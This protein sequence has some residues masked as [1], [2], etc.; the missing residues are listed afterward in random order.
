MPVVSWHVTEPAF[1]VLKQAIWS[2]S[3]REPARGTIGWG[4]VRAA[5]PI[6][7]PRRDVECP[8]CPAPH[9]ERPGEGVVSRNC[10]SALMNRTETRTENRTAT[11]DAERA[12]RHESR[13]AAEELRR[14][15]LRAGV[16]QAAVA[17]AVGTTRSLICRLEQGDPAVALRMRFRV[18]A[19][20]GADLRLMA[21][22]GSGPVIRDSV[23]AEVVEHLLRVRNPGWRATVE[24]DVPGPG[25]RSVDLR[26]DGPADTI[27]VEV[28]TRVDSLEGIVRELHAKR[29]AILE[30]FGAGAI[31]R[32]HVVLVLPVTRRHST[33]VKAHPEIIR[34]AFPVPSAVIRRALT[35]PATTC[36][37][38][39]LLWIRR[40][41]TVV[42]PGMTERS[43]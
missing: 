15:R 2:G 12:L 29:R 17:A 24:A 43:L 20:L 21:Y 34:A 18:A 36:P 33:M 41:G 27:L 7:S 38:D 16:S 35:G 30:S 10:C 39:G 6:V 40:Q 14:M 23:Q 19:V 25:S 22:A 26:L 31:R 8:F 5:A 13:R 28:E 3:D 11:R 1:R 37:G 42:T 4:Q 32:V 9:D